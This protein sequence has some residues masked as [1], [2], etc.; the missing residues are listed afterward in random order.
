MERLAIPRSFVQEFIEQAAREEKLL[1][2]VTDELR[3]LGRVLKRM[4]CLLRDL[5]DD[6]VEDEI[7]KHLLRKVKTLTYGAEDIVEEFAVQVASKRGRRGVKNVLKRFG[8]IFSEVK[9]LHNLGL[10]IALVLNEMN[11]VTKDFEIYYLKLRVVNEG[12]ENQ[13]RP[14]R[15]IRYAAR[16]KAEEYYFIGREEEISKLVTLLLPLP[17][18]SSSYIPV[19]CVW[20]VGGIGKTTITRKIYKHRDVQS[21]F[22]R[23]AWVCITQQAQ[24]RSVL[25]D[26]LIQLFPDQEK[27]GVEHMEDSELVQQLHRVQRENKCLIVLDDIWN[28]NDWGVLVSAFPLVE[29]GSKI[30]L[31]TRTKQVAE[32]IGFPYELRCL[33]DG[34]SWELLRKI[35]FSPRRRV[36][37]IKVEQ[38]IEAVGIEMVRK[39]DGIPLA[40]SVLGAILKD[41]YFF[42]DW[43]I[44]NRRIDSYQRNEERSDG[45]AVLRILSL[46]YNLL[47]YYLKQCFLYLGNFRE[48][49]DI[50]VEQI[51]LQWIADGM[52]L[53]QHQTSGDTLKDVAER[54]MNE[55]SQRSMVEVQMND[56][57][58]SRRFSSCCL[59]DSIRDFC[60]E[61][62]REEDFIRVIDIPCVEI[63]YNAAERLVIHIN[64]NVEAPVDADNL[65]EGSEPP[66]RS[67]LFRNHNLGVKKII[68]SKKIV[69]YKNLKS[70]RVLNFEGYDFGGRK[71]LP[72]GLETLIHLRLLSFRL[73]ILGELP[74]SIF[75]LPFLQTLDL[76]VSTDEIKIPNVLGK[77]KRLRHLYFPP[78]VTKEV[79]KQ[80]LRLHG[81]SELE[82]LDGLDGSRH[83]IADLDEL[84]NLRFF[85][86][87]V[88]DNDSLGDIINV[89][90]KNGQNLKETKLHIRG[91]VSLSSAGQGSVP[92]HL[93]DVLNCGNLHQLWLQ[94][95]IGEFP[96][97]EVNFLQG[98]VQLVLQSSEIVK[99]PMETLQNL[100]Q[101]RSLMLLPGAYEGKELICQKLGFPQLRNLRIDSLPNLSC[102]EIDEGGMPNLSC[103]EIYDCPELEMIPDGL[104]YVAGLKELLVY[105][106]PLVDRVKVAITR[107]K[108]ED[109]DK[110]QHISSI[111][112]NRLSLT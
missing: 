107:G 3:K 105:R 49:E 54:Y 41:K 26:V 22:E 24:I 4:Q 9:S 29:G 80:K 64:G 53:P 51:Y 28:V 50:D 88:T 69:N 20:G 31:T 1:S 14:P 62:G 38:K 98:L 74:S 2:G 6:R 61:K 85:A 59:H 86:A 10:K 18:Q 95:K 97:H 25:R 11:K 73:C 23:F 110:I 79:V 48:D 8:F 45:A 99:D 84:T 40:L 83:E 108:G 101:L 92:V 94:V 16:D 42:R 93:R 5:D 13:R 27:K 103:L 66:L 104:R 58:I 106:S 77:M 21:C 109:F 78:V 35:A 70:L 52:V 12:D 96:P 44:V 112:F 67:L 37:D 75:N 72:K 46:S 56:S 34:E 36:E 39:C 7:R 32:V 71:K 47:P 65:L 15:L 63:P 111:I 19:I 30:L 33:N 90:S 82:M 81:L 57:S 60:L 100:P 55:L 17:P 102:V 43:E 76:R 89:I 68:W 91:S 87:T